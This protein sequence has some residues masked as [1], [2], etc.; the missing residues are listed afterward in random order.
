[1]YDKD[2][3]LKKLKKLKTELVMSYPISELGLFGSYA[4]GS[5]TIHSDIDILIDFNKKIDGFD[6]IK[7]AHK[8][9]D[10]FDKKIDLVSRAGIADKYLPFVE[11]HLIYI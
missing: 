8:L 5:F 3:I 2:F 10:N 4:D 1:M 9:E 6:Y 7:I 11:K